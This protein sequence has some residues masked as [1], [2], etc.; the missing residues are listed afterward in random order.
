[1]D[2]H[3]FRPLTDDPTAIFIADF[4]RVACIVLTCVVVPIVARAI[5]KQEWNTGRDGFSWRMWAIVVFAVTAGLNQIDRLHQPVTAR[6]FLNT[7]ALVLLIRGVLP[8]L[9]PNTGRAEREE[10]LRGDDQ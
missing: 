10:W 1:M 7:L 4:F 3:I 8:L 9:R 5:S 2:E 6:L